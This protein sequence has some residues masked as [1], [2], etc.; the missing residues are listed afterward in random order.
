MPRP[1][2]VARAL[3]VAEK[4]SRAAH[5]G[6]KYGRMAS[7]DSAST[8]PTVE[9]CHQSCRG[10]VVSPA[11][12]ANINASSASA[13]HP[14]HRA[15]QPVDESQPDAVDGASR[16]PREKRAHDENNDQYQREGE[17]MARGRRD[18]EGGKSDATGSA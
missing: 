11:I 7:A 16:D 6:G 3:P 12:S 18:V 5:S 8:G 10:S 1:L 13:Q 17:C 14:E 4:S 15:E 2:P 9:F